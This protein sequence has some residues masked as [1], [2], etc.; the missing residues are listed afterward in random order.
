MARSV[1]LGGAA[2]FLLLL[3]LV[4]PTVQG[5]NNG[6]V[7]LSIVAKPLH[8]VDKNTEAQ[9]STIIKNR[10]L[11]LGMQDISVD[12]VTNQSSSEILFVIRAFPVNSTDV[13][14]IKRVLSDKGLLYFEFGGTVF[15]TG[16]D[17]TVPSGQYG[18]DLRRGPT[19]WYVNFK[20]SARAQ[21]NFKQIAAHKVGWPVDIFFDPPVD[22]LIL[23][24]PK[25]Y[26]E[27][28]D[29]K[30]FNG[31]AGSQAPTLLE[32]IQEAFNITVI[33]YSD[34]TPEE[35]VNKAVDLNKDSIILADV[36]QDLYNNVS[37][38]VKKENLEKAVS[39][40]APQSGEDVESFIKRILGLYGP[41]SLAFDPAEGSLR[42]FW[43]TGSASTKEAALQ[44]AK[45]LYA[46]LKGG[47]LPVRLEIVSA[48]YYT[49]TT[50]TGE[51]RKP[52]SDGEQ[53]S[54]A[55][56]GKTGSA[57]CGPALMV[58]FG[59]APLLLRRRK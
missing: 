29:V 52:S 38:I 49:P 16:A 20:L 15:A 17:V 37:S 11:A 39:Y 35:I 57:V 55:G 27:L 19:A 14:Q 41:Y 40:F 28:Q 46:V 42:E 54:P 12:I 26:N 23:A 4:S 8:P 44:E 30:A 18:L 36:P 9:V 56:T 45:T 51:N 43:I 32:R 34:Q 50:S 21:N 6:P 25:L 5:V 59:I 24:S 53:A 3:L 7:G 31:Q 33:Q 10:L 22:S 13:E 48:D 1:Y 2:V 47:A 58:L